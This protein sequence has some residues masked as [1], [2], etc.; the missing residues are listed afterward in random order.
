MD[1]EKD[2]WDGSQ[3]SPQHSGEHE[4]VLMN[5]RKDSIVLQEAA[6]LYGDIQTAESEYTLMSQ[7]RNT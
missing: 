2:A 7:A 3:S 1:G 6:D 4:A 5:D